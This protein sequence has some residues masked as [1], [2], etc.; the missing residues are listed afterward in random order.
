MVEWWNET[1]PRLQA[2]TGFL[3][4][5]TTTAPTASQDLTSFGL[6][7]LCKTHTLVNLTVPRIRHVYPACLLAR[8]HRPA[9][10][11]ATRSLT[12][13]PHKHIHKHTHEARCVLAS[14]VVARR[15]DGRPVRH[16]RT[17]NASTL[18]PGHQGAARAEGA[19]PARRLRR[20]ALQLA[21]CRPLVGLAVAHGP[22]GGA[23]DGAQERQQ[24]I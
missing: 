23:W 7:L 3:A 20:A 1:R 18:T 17:L 15:T 12:Q 2:R 16:P 4:A 14:V 19:A 22:A 11:T 13:S 6:G 8:P 21:Q 9:L 5:T 24:I 10:R